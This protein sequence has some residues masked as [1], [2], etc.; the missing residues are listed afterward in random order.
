LYELFL[1][2]GIYTSH[3]QCVWSN[4]T[5]YSRF[6]A[7]HNNNNKVCNFIFVSF[8]EKVFIY[9]SENYLT[10]KKRFPMTQNIFFLGTVSAVV[11]FFSFSVE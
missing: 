5:E 11:V 8:V 10:I 9:S 2:A 1:N 6:V 7:F 3:N 4:T